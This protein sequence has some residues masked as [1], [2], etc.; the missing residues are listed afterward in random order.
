MSAPDQGLSVTMEAPAELL[1]SRI[2]T[3]RQRWLADPAKYCDMH[4]PMCRLGWADSYWEEMVL[5][6]EIEGRA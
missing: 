4:N 3:E 2:L 1:L 5:T 6:A